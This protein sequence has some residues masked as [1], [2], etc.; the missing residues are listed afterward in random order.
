MG[1]CSDP[2]F[3]I[4]AFQS[5]KIEVWKP[6]QASKDISAGYLLQRLG[7]NLRARLFMADFVAKVGWLRWTVDCGL[8]QPALIR[9]P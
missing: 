1:H 7:A 9:R 4:I 3:P 6:R 8:E 2:K 5:R